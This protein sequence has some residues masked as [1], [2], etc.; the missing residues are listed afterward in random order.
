MFT[1]KHRSYYSTSLG[2][3]ETIALANMIYY[4]TKPFTVLLLCDYFLRRNDLKR[5]AFK[6]ANIS[7]LY[8][9]SVCNQKLSS[10]YKVNYNKS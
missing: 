6:E 5:N 1:Y 10:K 3:N 4:F 2:F 9:I 7:T 8:E